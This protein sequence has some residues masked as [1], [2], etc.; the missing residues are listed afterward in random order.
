MNSNKQK[1]ISIFI[2][3]ALVG[4]LFI[5]HGV[6]KVLDPSGTA[7]FFESLGLIGILG[8][9]VGYVEIIAGILLLIG[10][11]TKWASVAIGVI[12]IGAIVLVQA[13]NGYSAGLARDVL[14]LA[15]VYYFFTNG[16]GTVA[17][18]HVKPAK[19]G[20]KKKNMWK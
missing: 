7:G 15:L 10:V 3:R 4:I 12:M 5:Y 8:P 6:Q 20:S 18:E 13:A 16:P 11:W 14:L 17:I 2:M 9:I 19:K 1:N